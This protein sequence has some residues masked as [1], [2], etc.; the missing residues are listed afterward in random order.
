MMRAQMLH[1]LRAHAASWD[2][3]VIGGG[4]TGVGVAIDSAS[5]DV[6]NRGRC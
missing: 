2:I 3:I 4:A 5:Y 6:K 1:R